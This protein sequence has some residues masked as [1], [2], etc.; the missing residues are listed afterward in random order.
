MCWC[1]PYPA[2]CGRAPPRCRR[3]RKPNIV[4][5]YA[6][7]LGYGDLGCYGATKVKTPN[8][9]GSRGGAALHRRPLA[10]GHLHA[11]A[12]RAAHRASTP[13]GSKGTGILPGDAALIIEPGTADAAVGA[14]EGRLRDRRRR[15]VA[16]RPRRR[17]TIDW[18][19]EIKPGPLEVGFD[20]CF[21]IPATGDR[22]PCVYVE[23]RRVVGLDPNDPIR[24][25]YGKKVGD[26]PTGQG[27]P[28]AAQDEAEPRAT[29]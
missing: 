20:Y 3:D 28:R 6:D 10:V 4:L 5:I 14:E 26:E 22:V 15:Q 18:N 11:V 24:V 23:N 16:P 1:S 2:A 27:E 8:S 7:D 17:A 25:S 29:T 19:G 9:T 21:I 12:V 13:G